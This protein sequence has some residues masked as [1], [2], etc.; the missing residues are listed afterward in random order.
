MIYA[1]CS[2]TFVKA[3]AKVTK[4]QH[5]AEV[6]STGNSSGPHL[7]F[8]VRNGARWSASKDV[9]PQPVLDI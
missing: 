5:I 6:G 4:G 8:E 3:G 2:K 9:N 1:H 7:H